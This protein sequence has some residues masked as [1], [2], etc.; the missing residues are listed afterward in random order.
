MRTAEFTERTASLWPRPGLVPLQA[1]PPPVAPRPVAH[2]RPGR[3]R[4]VADAMLPLA[5]LIVAGVAV[6]LPASLDSKARLA[7]FAFAVAAI[8]WSTTSFNP[9]YVA[10]TAVLLLVFTGAR[11]QQELFEALASDVVW[12]MIG[13]FVLGEAVERSGL[14]G[15]MAQLVVSRARSVSGMCWLLTTVLVPLTF[16]VPSTSGRAAV[17]IPLFRSVTGADGDRRVTRVVALLMP[18]VILVSTIATVIGAG[19]HLIANDLLEQIADRRLSFAQWA[20][21]GV[22]FALAASYL[23][24][25]VVLRLFLRREQRQQALRIP[26]SRSRPLSAAEWKTLAVVVAMVVLWLTESRHG[27]EIATVTV[28]GAVVLTA[29]A[30]GVLRWKDGLKAVSWNLVVFVGAALVLGRALIDTGAAQWIIDRL[31]AVSSI[32]G[33][34]SHLLVLLILALISLTSH[35]YMT[36]HSAR[37]AA[38]VPPLLYL[39]GSLGVDPA[40]VM[41]IGTAGMDYCLTFPVSSKALLMFQELEGETYQPADL[42]R[43]SSVLL[44]MHLGLMVAFYFGYWRYVGLSL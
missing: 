17:T 44:L 18:T 9:A 40:A 6:L 4:W 34:D 24:C 16:L 36:S 12:L 28:V 20:L 25:W 7:L 37:A 26:A 31:F 42:L 13:A 1:A 41:F 27:L 29:P 15:R 21:Y 8:L 30:G 3:L 38:L 32:A 22:P 35:L 2:H 23:S 11:P 19:S 43:L 5:L 39:A 14:A 33:A 10:L